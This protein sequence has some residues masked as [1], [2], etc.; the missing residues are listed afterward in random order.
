MLRNWQ[1]EEQEA[2]LKAKIEKRARRDLT[3]V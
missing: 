3:R 1:L 2:K